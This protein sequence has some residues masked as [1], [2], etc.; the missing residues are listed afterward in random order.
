MMHKPPQLLKLEMYCRVCGRELNPLKTNSVKS[1]TFNQEVCYACLKE[2]AEQD[3]DHRSFHLIIPEVTELENDVIMNGFASSKFFGDT[4]NGMIWTKDLINACKITTPTQLSGV[5]DSLVKKELISY[6]GTGA[7]STVQ[8]TAE[9]YH[10][11]LTH[12]GE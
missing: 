4:T 10:Y 12:R 5:V 2:N 3:N 6:N 1:S 9:G 8:L 11:Y 7:N